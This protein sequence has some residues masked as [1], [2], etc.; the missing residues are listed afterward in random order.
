MA[1]GLMEALGA[2]K[3]KGGD[4]GDEEALLLLAEPETDR[5]GVVSAMQEFIAASEEG[6]AE[7]M[8]DAL[9]SAVELLK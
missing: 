6:D 3:K 2:S 1:K 5:D 8:A 7:A 4:D 9:M